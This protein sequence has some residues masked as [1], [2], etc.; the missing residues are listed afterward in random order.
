[1]ETK[2]T[3]G[4]WFPDE[5]GGIWRRDPKDLYENGG[6]VAGDKPLAIVH[7]GWRGENVQGYPLEAN[8][9]LIAAAPDLLRAAIQVE[10]ILSQIVDQ[11]SDTLNKLRA[12]IAKA[13]T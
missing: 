10:A 3:P 9:R 6:G 4:P 11:P 7:I 13:T 5:H 1:M 12:A 2:F 8:A